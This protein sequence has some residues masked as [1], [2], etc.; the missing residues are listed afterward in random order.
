VSADQDPVAGLT[1]V[2]GSPR[3]LYVGSV[4]FTTARRQPAH[5]VRVELGMWRVGGA[6]TAERCVSALLRAWPPIVCDAA[7]RFCR[8]VLG[9]HDVQMCR[10][11]VSTLSGS[12]VRDDRTAHEFSRTFLV[13]QAFNRLGRRAFDAKISDV[14][15][16]GTNGGE[17]C[18]H[19]PR[20]ARSCR[21]GC[22]AAARVTR[23]LFRGRSHSAGVTPARLTVM[24]LHR[25][26]EQAHSSAAI[27]AQP[28]WARPLCG[29]MSLWCAQ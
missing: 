19:L 14:D 16:D 13:Y 1:A 25:P 29:M 3:S 4:L 22:S 5:R 6:A 28:L 21:C 20:S 15:P 17:T 7:I 23:G 2:A 26:R 18:T 27:R 10:S 11:G 9:R 24:G 8:C 12:C